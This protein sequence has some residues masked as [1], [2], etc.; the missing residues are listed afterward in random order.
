MNSALAATGPL[1]LA[2]A[3][4]GCSIPTR[5]GLPIVENS[6]AANRDCGDGGVCIATM[7][8]ATSAK[9]E[10]VFVEVDAPTSGQNGAHLSTIVALA[11]LGIALDGTD[12]QGHV[13]TLD[14]MATRADV[15]AHFLLDYKA[16]PCPQFPKGVPFSLELQPALEVTGIP[17]AVYFA[18]SNEAE[19]VTASLHVPFGNYDIYAVPQADE[20]ASVKCQLPP[21]LVRNVSVESSDTAI[22]FAPSNPPTV[23][24][25]K[26]DADLTDWT[27]TLVDNEDGRELST[28][29]V[30]T[31]ATAPTLS[32]AFYLSA[33]PRVFGPDGFDTVLRIAPPQTPAGEGRPT[34]LW[35]LSA[36][37][38][39]SPPFAELKT[40]G[41]LER[42]VSAME[43]TVVGPDGAGVSATVSIRSKSF[44]SMAGSI[45][46]LHTVVL[47]DE[48]GWFTAKLIAGNYRVV[49]VPTG[50]T[51]FAITA[52]DWEKKAGAL[53][54]GL[55]IQL[56]S[57]S[58]LVGN[59]TLANGKPAYGV[60]V[61][62]EPAGNDATSIFEK[63]FDV[64]A[65]QVA[66]TGRITVTDFSGFFQ[67]VVDPGQFDFSLRPEPDAQLPWLVRPR[68][69]VSDGAPYTAELGTVSISNPIV[70]RGSVHNDGGDALANAAIRVWHA[71][72]AA[73]GAPLSAAV[74]IAESHSEADGTY[75]LLVPSAV[76]Q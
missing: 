53:P 44:D 30:I 61:L 57:L 1:L 20:G 54:G 27:V 5:E 60:S 75:S 23:L 49:A 24:K 40:S 13:K 7:C 8:V 3:A 32:S 51:D 38:L 58:R 50:V 18:D 19:E 11:D 69:S 25:G 59:A 15:R 63:E 33:W 71:P 21:M 2:L 67:L 68:I 76:S 72:H 37:G 66:S 73:A 65:S 16:L 22:K 42:P 26:I 46:A 4:L 45:A 10:R 64:R 6:C 17:F 9:L 36:L 56:A 70:L 52:I 43:G 31:V 39:G 74:L 35:K 55:S 41:L 62:A 28:P 29:A 12:P 34:L 14:L 47:T 48:N